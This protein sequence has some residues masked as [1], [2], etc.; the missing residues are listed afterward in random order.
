MS[1]IGTDQNWFEKLL[2]KNRRLKKWV[3][4]LVFARGMKKLQKSAFSATYKTVWCAGPTIENTTAI[5]PV[6]EIVESL[7][8]KE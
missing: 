4:M 7:V 5:R 6:K 2:S 8:I 1:R 3:K